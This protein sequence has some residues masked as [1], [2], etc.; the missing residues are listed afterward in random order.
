MPPDARPGVE[1]H[2][3]VRLGGRR[4]DDLPDIQPHALA[5]EGQ[6]VDEGDVHVAEDVLID[7]HHL[8]DRA[9]TDRDHLRGDRLVEETGELG[10]PGRQ[11]AD[12][13]RDRADRSLGVAGV[14]PLRGERQVKIPPGEQAGSF[15]DGLHP[16]L[17]R[18]RIG[19]ALQHDELPPAEMGDQLAYGR[20]DVRE[21]RLLRPRQRRGHA[22]DH[23]VGPGRPGGILRGREV[24][25][26]GQRRR[27][28]V[29]HV[30]DV[31]GPA[32]H[33]GHAVG[34]R[35]EPDHAESGPPQLHREGQP[36]IPQADD[37][38]RRRA[39]AELHFKIHGH[40]P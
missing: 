12:D 10:A 20:V 28:V 32:V 40:P 29:L 5:E 18:A 1:G 22:D 30:V 25:L 37:Q 38:D 9:R 3:P 4:G 39:I 16:L 8:R 17:R 23:R 27:H 14:E 34:V 21:I 6:L 26:R 24:P 19:R 7:F 15:Q 2:E 35:V 36:H 33:R 13:L 11:P 31:G